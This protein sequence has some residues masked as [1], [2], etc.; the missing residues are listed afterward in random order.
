MS[1]TF[2]TYFTPGDSFITSD[3]LQTLRESLVAPVT[4]NRQRYG[5]A[6]VLEAVHELTAIRAPVV[7]LETAEL[8]RG[9]HGV[10]LSK[11]GPR[12]KMAVWLGD[13]GIRYHD[14]IL[15]PHVSRLKLCPFHSVTAGF[16]SQNARQDDSTP[17]QAADLSVHGRVNQVL[18]LLGFWR[19]TATSRCQRLCRGGSSSDK[20]FYYSDVF[21]E[22]AHAKI[23][24]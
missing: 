23:F 5:D 1:G 9:V 20:A 15:W 6:L 10:S 7:Q 8:Q 4:F 11:R 14:D 3:S 12:S 19:Q 13:V 18:Q 2:Q 17:P 22:Q 24:F 21:S 16:D